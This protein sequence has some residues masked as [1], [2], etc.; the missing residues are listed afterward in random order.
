MVSGSDRSCDRWK[1][2]YVIEGAAELTLHQL[3]RT[4]SLLGEPLADQ[5]DATPFSPRCFKDLIEED[6]HFARRDL[7]T[8]L[9]LVFFDTTSI[10]F[11]GEGGKTLGERG[12]S[13][14]QIPGAGPA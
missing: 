13:K 1:R 2:D 9:E 12:H 10:Y 4:M 5:E 7:L 8:E 3:Y 14:D 6:L 11:E